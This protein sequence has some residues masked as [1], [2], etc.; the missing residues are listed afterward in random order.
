M[1]TENRGNRRDH[2]GGSGL[3]KRADVRAEA[4]GRSRGGYIPARIPRAQ[5]PLEGE[6]PLDVLR[7]L[8]WLVKKPHVFRVAMGS[9]PIS[10]VDENPLF[11]LCGKAI[12]SCGECRRN[13]RGPFVPRLDRVNAILHTR[14]EIF[15]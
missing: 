15:Q 12:S 9:P 11:S 6:M 5:H 4:L 14:L 2:D 8:G 7:A 10:K 3:A 1:F 13:G